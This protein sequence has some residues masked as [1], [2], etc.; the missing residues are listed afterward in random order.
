MAVNRLAETYDE[1]PYG[2]VAFQQTHPGRLAVTGRLLGLTPPPVETCRVLEVGCADGGNL[3]PLAATIPGGRFLGVELSQ[4]QAE[5]G[6]RKIAAAGLTNVEILNADLLDVAASLGEFDYVI[7]YGVLSWVPPVVREKLLEVCAR[8]LSPHGIAYVNYN[9]WP[10][11]SARN[12]LRDVLRYHL[13]DGGPAADQV[14]RARAFHALLLENVK[15]RSG[16]YPRLLQVEKEWSDKLSPGNYYHDLLEEQNVPFWFHEVASMAR[17]HGLQ[18]LGEADLAAMPTAAFHPEMDRLVRRL[19]SDRVEREQYADILRNR[20]FRET[21]LCRSGIPVREEPDP[22]VMAELFFTSLAR[23]DGD[24]PD[25]APGVEV[26]FATRVRRSLST[27]DPVMKAALLELSAAWPEALTIDEVLPRALRR[28]GERAEEPGPARER[29]AGYFL[30]AHTAEVIEGLRYRVAVAREARERPRALPTARVE[31]EE[32][33]FVANAWHIVVE[34]GDL[35]RVVLGFLDG[36]RDRAALV[37]AVAERAAR[38]GLLSDAEGRPVAD[39]ATV[40]G[41]VAANLEASLG[42][43]AESALLVP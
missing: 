34:M 5:A 31:A 27:N 7:A 30:G 12:V 9:A 36:T 37:E 1:L 11:S 25:L 16:N 42:R 20:R 26:K 18:Y 24:I 2:S 4:R 41:V 14:E 38:E 39:P 29:L 15:D 28:L 23:P 43:I 32:S 21:L 17:R 19:G 8:C 10:G 40:R 13:R 3:L 33:R 6:Q 22:E 35:E